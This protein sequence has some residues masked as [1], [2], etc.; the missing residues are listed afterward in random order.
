[1]RT[2][3]SSSRRLAA[4]DGTL[5]ATECGVSGRSARAV[6]HEGEHPADRAGS[7]NRL[8][9]PSRLLE[10]PHSFAELPEPHAVVAD[11][12]GESASV[13]GST[14]GSG[15]GSAAAVAD[16]TSQLLRYATIAACRS[17][18]AKSVARKRNSTTSKSS[19]E[20]A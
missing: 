19:F 2:R 3:A 1:M 15:C 11:Q 10:H 17:T 4:A 8:V 16:D 20:G 6:A 12:D 14:D 5:C 9:A 18:A 13:V 7:A